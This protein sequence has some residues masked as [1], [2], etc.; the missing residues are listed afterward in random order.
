MELG[1][2]KII[3]ENRDNPCLHTTFKYMEPNSKQVFNV[4]NILNE[5]F[6]M[7]RETIIGGGSE[8]IFTEGSNIST[9]T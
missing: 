4:I 5:K 7:L 6:K 8:A 3:K 1:T 2:G 9:E